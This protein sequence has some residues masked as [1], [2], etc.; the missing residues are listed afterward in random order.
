M[1]ILGEYPTLDEDR[2]LS[3]IFISLSLFISAREALRA[4]LPGPLRDATFSQLLKNDHVSD[5]STSTV[6]DNSHSFF[7]SEQITKRCLATLLL[8][9]SDR[10]ES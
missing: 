2:P 6:N 5:A 9:L 7:C 4:C 1:I 10:V 3:D 8:N